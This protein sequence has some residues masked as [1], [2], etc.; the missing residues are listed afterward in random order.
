[1]L[2]PRAKELYCGYPQERALFLHWALS[3]T[4]KLFAAIRY[5]R[6]SRSPMT[7]FVPKKEGSETSFPPD[8][9]RKSPRTRDLSKESYPMQQPHP[10]EGSDNLNPGLLAAR[11][12]YPVAEGA[13]VRFEGADGVPSGHKKGAEGVF[14]PFRGA[15]GKVYP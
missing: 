11:S 8:P 4:K 10:K 9:K 13:S 5:P 3:R 15:M 14:A 7:G 6:R 2:F 1:M 12:C